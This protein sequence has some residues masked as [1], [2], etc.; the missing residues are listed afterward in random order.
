MHLRNVEIFC[1]V[2][3]RRS[4]SKAA[5]AHHVSQSLASQAVHQLEDR[6]GTL[7]I[8]RSKRPLEL[9]FAGRLYFE[10]CRELLVSFHAIEDRVRELSN[11]VVGRVRVAAIYSVGLLQMSVYAQRFRELYP[12]V[13]LHLEYLHPD[14]VI[15]RVLE[16]QVDLGLISFPQSNTEL[17]SIPWQQQLMTLVVPPTHRLAQRSSIA[18][19]EIEGESFVGFERDLW[20]RKQIDRWLKS[21]GVS[22]EIIHQF[23]NIENIKRAVE[24]GSGIS[25]LPQPMV[26]RESEAG[27][28]LSVPFDNVRWYRPLGIIHRK[29]RT[30]STAMSKFIELL[31]QDT[32]KLG[33]PAYDGS[34]PRTSRSASTKLKNT[35]TSEKTRC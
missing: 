5:E 13:E 14:E 6:L 10:G 2:A 27:T 17:G 32:D 12:E 8:D 21:A 11:Q 19:K 16:E 24:I 7:L 4:F 29:N 20:I 26:R 30:F 34:P 23:D 28:L 18:V 3:S 35:P 31:Q 15:Q 33:E 1:D 25:I 9:T 22:V